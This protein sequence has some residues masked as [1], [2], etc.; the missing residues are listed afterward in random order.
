MT[1]R[2]E[3]KK[4]KEGGAFFEDAS[5]RVEGA[6][7]VDASSRVEESFPPSRVEGALSTSRMEEAEGRRSFHR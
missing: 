5:S 2:V 1:R 4:W 6:F 3:W 7:I